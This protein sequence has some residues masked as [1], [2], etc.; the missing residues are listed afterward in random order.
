MPQSQGATE[1]YLLSTLARVR[2]I[3]QDDSHT[4]CTPEQ[5]HDVLNS[6]VKIVGEFFK[7]IDMPFRVRLSFRDDTEN[8]LGDRALWD[9]AQTLIKEVVE[10]NGLEYFIATGEAAFYGPKIDFIAQ[11]ALGREWQLATPQLDFIQPQRF[12]LKYTDTDGEL[13]T[14][15][16][17]HFALL[18]SIER[19]LS[20]Y[21]EHTA[22]RFPVWL[23]PEQIRVLTINQDKATVDFANSIKNKAFDLGI[24]VTVDDNSESV[25]KKIREAEMMKVPYS[26]VIGQKEIENGQVTP[27]VRGDLLQSNNDK[28]FTVDEFLEQVRKEASSRSKT[29]FIGQ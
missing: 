16:M 8:Y 22:G 28:S 1:I 3:T 19:F 24:R 23:A 7:A 5:I 20:A 2:A 17:V 10:A 21:I 25:G 26:I 9:R 11:D 27:R 18:G 14:P 13:K 12:G 6:L 15:V 4:F 29:S